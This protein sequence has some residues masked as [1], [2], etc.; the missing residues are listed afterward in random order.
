MR[1]TMLSIIA[2]AALL[3][4]SRGEEDGNAT[5]GIFDWWNDAAELL[6]EACSAECGGAQLVDDTND[7]V[8]SLKDK[9][10]FGSL[11]KFKAN[12]GPFAEELYT[13]VHKLFCEA[14]AVADCFLTNAAKCASGGKWQSWTDLTNAFSALT[15]FFSMDPE[16]VAIN[17]VINLVMSG[18][19]KVKKCTCDVCPGVANAVGRFLG[20]SLTALAEGIDT[21]LSKAASNMRIEM[22]EG[23]CPMVGALDCMEGKVQTGFV[24]IKQQYDECKVL[25]DELHASVARKWIGAYLDVTEKKSTEEVCKKEEI[26]TRLAQFTSNSASLGSLAIAAL[27]I[28][29]ALTY[30]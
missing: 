26:D 17:A 28:I 7:L 27:A 25:A 21:D 22:L 13:G 23:I 29:S 9:F 4:T 15:S 30:F 18:V 11:D 5:R 1:S 16:V 14:Y 2:F 19:A 8:K 12:V 24:V 10:Q 6:P 20:S 3:G